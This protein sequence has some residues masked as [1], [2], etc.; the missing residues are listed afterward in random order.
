MAA[1]KFMCTTDDKQKHDEIKKRLFFSGGAIIREKVHDS[2]G[3]FSGELEM[4][5]EGGTL[6][7]ELRESELSLRTVLLT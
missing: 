5:C 1:V 4:V 7:K 6:Y 3:G 2:K